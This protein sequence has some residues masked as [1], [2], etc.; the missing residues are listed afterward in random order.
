MFL[1]YIIRS[2]GNPEVP[3][4]LRQA[5]GQAAPTVAKRGEELW[6]AVLPFKSS[7]YAQMESS[8]NGLGED[9]TTGLSRFR[10]LSVVVSASAAQLKGETGDERA[11]GAKLGARYV[12]EGRIRKGGS[13]I[14]VT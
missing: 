1:I 3:E 13:G 12:L 2:W 7:G 4:K 10:Y 8:A 5:K 11:L 6:V 9:I 14:R